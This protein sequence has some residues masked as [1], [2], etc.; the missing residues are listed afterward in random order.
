MDAADYE[1]PQSHER[2]D[3]WRSVS[4]GVPTRRGRAI[5]HVWCNFPEPA[6][7]HDASH[8]G[9]SFT[10]RQRIKRKAA[11][12]VRMLESMPAAERAAILEAL[13]TMQACIDAGD[14]P[15]G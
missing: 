8:V 15:A 12:W 6:V 4:F 14:N 1:G 2:L 3:R 5:E 10:D 11:R 13:A 9:E 7:L